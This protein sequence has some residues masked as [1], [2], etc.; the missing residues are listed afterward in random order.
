[1]YK[2]LFSQSEMLRISASGRQFGRHVATGRA[3][4]AAA[5]AAVC[6][7]GDGFLRPHP[8]NVTRQSSRRT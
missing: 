6:F 4:G 2:T 3:I 8:A 7:H 1:M 5:G